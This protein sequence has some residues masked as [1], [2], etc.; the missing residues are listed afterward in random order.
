M[1]DCGGICRRQGSENNASMAQSLRS[2]GCITVGFRQI[3][4]E[5]GKWRATTRRLSEQNST[6]LIGHFCSAHFGP[7]FV[8][9]HSNHTNSHCLKPLNYDA[10]ARLVTG[11][12]QR[13]VFPVSLRKAKTSR[14]SVPEAAI[15][16]Y[17]H[18]LFGKPKI[19]TPWNR[20]GVHFPSNDCRSH[21][22]EPQSLL[23]RTVAGG[24]DLRH[25]RASF[26]SCQS[27]HSPD[28]GD[29]L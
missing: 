18:P 7:E 28:R 6:D 14:A 2:K 20:L 8:L 10:C 29:N 19:W 21:E 15:H 27:V 12:F 1:F 23:R 3:E 22:N 5:P 4:G 26:V 17:C 16:K 13:P 9:P 11:D 24:S 25:E